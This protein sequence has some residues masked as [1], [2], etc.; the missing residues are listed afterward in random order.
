MQTIFAFS[1]AQR[2]RLKTPARAYGRGKRGSVLSPVFDEME[3]SPSSHKLI[4][5][6][7]GHATKFDSE[8]VF[9]NDLSTLTSSSAS[10]REFPPTSKKLAVTPTGLKLSVSSQ[11]LASCCSTALRGA[12]YF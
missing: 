11:M 6:I 3:A 8:R 10:C 1:A 9:L 5:S 2:A 4:C 12:T 7:V